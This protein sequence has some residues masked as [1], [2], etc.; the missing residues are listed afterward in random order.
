MIPDY[1]ISV[2]IEHVVKSKIGTIFVNEKILEEYSVKIYEI[3]PYF[4]EHYKKKIQVDNNDQEYILFR[5]DIYFT[6]YFLAVEIDKKGH[7][8]N[9]LIFEEKRQKALEKK[10]NCTF[11]KINTSKENYDGGYEAS[12]IQTLISNFNKNKRKELEDKIKHLS[13]KNNINYK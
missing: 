1:E 11:I 7:T 9:D 12:R 2:S 8:D 5:I 6:E 10:L 13:V 3:D 4:Y